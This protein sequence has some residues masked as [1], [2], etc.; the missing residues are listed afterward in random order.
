M[1]EE[2]QIVAGWDDPRF[3]TVRGI[4]RRGLTTEALKQ[5]ML[6]QGPSQAVTSLEWD[7]IWTT[8]KKVIDP[9]APRY[10]AVDKKDM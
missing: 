10:T 2:Q 5:Y 1:V 3:P 9:I 8:N 6:A 7:G 4:K